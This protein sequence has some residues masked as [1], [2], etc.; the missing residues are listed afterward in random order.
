MH[1]ALITHWHGD[2]VNGIADL[3]RICPKATIYKHD[4][5][6][7]Q[8][9][10]EEGQVF[11]TDGATLKALHTPGHTMDHMAFV[12]EEEDAIFTG[13]SMLAALSIPSILLGV[14]LLVLTL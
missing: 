1:Q 4:P 8:M 13:D 6:E 5:G 2:H 14:G 11:T 7:G 3:L 12:L 10:I 9:G